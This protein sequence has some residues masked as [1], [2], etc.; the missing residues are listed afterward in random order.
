MRYKIIK[1]L[2]WFYITIGLVCNQWFLGR[3]LAQDGVIHEVK[4]RIFIWLFET[5]L[6]IFGILC[7]KKN[8]TELIA[9][10][11]LSL[12]ITVILAPPLG[13]IMFR[14]GIAFNVPQLK[15]PSLYADS[16]SDDDYWKFQWDWKEDGGNI[17]LPL[18]RLHPLLG[19]TQ[20]DFTKDNPLGLQEDTK[21]QM[22]STTPKILFYGDSFVKG[23]SDKEFYIPQYMNSKMDGLYVVDL[24]VGGY[25]PD[26]VYLMFKETYQKV[27]NSTKLILVGILPNDD[28]DR[29]VLSIRTSQK[30]YFVIDSMGNLQLK[31]VPIE[32]DQKKYFRNYSVSIKSYLFS[33]IKQK[34]FEGRSYKSDMKKQINSKLLELFKVNANHAKSDL[35]FVIFYG[36]D[37]LTKNDWQEEFLKKKLNQLNL[38]YI[39][40][41]DFLL[42][43]AQKN[44]LELSSFYKRG[45]GHH[46]NLGNRVITDGIVQYLRAN[47]YI[48]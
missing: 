14:M 32:L 44:Q 24:S 16:F 26:Q 47:N 23:A 43:Y 17:M 13:E 48:K 4:S 35:L 42:S 36:K 7:L 45:N 3:L 9:N 22:E 46:N 34:L 20:A 1:I 30:P 25:G 21:K 8:K 40:T 2:G 18:K 29:T 37:S 15:T 5:L 10:L 39:D 41:K 6:I 28:L 12:W 33:F 19:W 11:N 31:G 38:H 27:A